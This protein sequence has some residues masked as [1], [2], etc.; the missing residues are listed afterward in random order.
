MSSPTAGFTRGRR[1]SDEK[2]NV[3]GVFSRLKLL[4]TDVDLEQREVEVNETFR[5]LFR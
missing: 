4:M 5:K 1:P 2:K 3:P